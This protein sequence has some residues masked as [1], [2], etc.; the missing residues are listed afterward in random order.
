[1]TLLQTAPHPR[2]ISPEDL[3]I[4]MAATQRPDLLR[5]L[6]TTS[7]A[8]FGFYTSHFPHT[9][10]YPWLVAK[11]EHLPP[12]ARVLDVGAGVSPVPVVLAE[13]G[14]LVECVDNHQVVRTLP[15]APDWNEWGYFDY[16]PLHKNL[17]SYHCSVTEFAPPADY[18]AIYSMS[19]LAHLTRDS[20]REALRR[21]RR[22]LRPDGL[23]LLTLDIIPSSDFI[24]NRSEGREVEP[25]LQHGTVNGL[26]EELAE[27]GFHTEEVNLLRTVHK[28]RTDLL[29]LICSVASVDTASGPSGG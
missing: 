21:C 8:A 18:D 22:W 15:S 14:L 13:K 24:W 3:T 4:A 23:L 17:T 5:E 29:F 28:S 26:L 16:A 2:D 11:L 6:V 10:N 20:R 27:L 7:R 9:I 25:P 19:A 1:M 12:G